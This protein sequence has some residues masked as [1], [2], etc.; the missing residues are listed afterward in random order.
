MLFFFLCSC[1]IGCFGLRAFALTCASASVPAF[2]LALCIYG[3]HQPIF[4]GIRRMLIPFAG[5][6]LLF[7]LS[8]SLPFFC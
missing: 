3:M 4:S 2:M 1:P 7:L 6:V 5:C 8:D